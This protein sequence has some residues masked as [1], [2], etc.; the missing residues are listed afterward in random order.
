MSAAFDYPDTLDWLEWQK[1]YRFGALYI[2][3]PTGIIEPVDELRGK[4]DPTSAGA[5]QAHLS[6]SEPLLGPL[7]DAQLAELRQ[8][9]A[10]IEP[11]EVHYGPLR[12]FPPYPGA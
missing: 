10:S 5:A 7:T 1:E 9:L 12:S 3:P 2:F 6:L 8:T 4:Y 11:F